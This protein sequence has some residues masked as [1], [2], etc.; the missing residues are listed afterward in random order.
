M[1]FAD[2]AVFKAVAEEGGVTAA[3]RRLHRVQSSVTMRIQHLEQSLGT[4]LFIR[5]RRR[6]VLSPAGELFRGYVDQLL[7]LGERARAAAA[8]DAPQGALRLG[9]LESTAASRLPP[10]LSAYHRAHKAVRVELVTGTTDALVEALLERRVDAAFVAEAPRDPRLEARAAFAEALVLIT[11]RDHPAVHAPRDV[12]LDTI[13]AFPAGC[14]YRRR[15]ARWLGPAHAAARVLELASYHAIVACVAS[16]TGVAL[17][18]RSVLATVRSG[19][20]VR[21]HPL[22]R[23]IARVVTALLRRRNERAP[24]IDAL[25]SLLTPTRHSSREPA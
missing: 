21:A 24:A 11:P 22:P 25:Q 7:E 13:I 15:L 1:D 3:A 8:G 12:A 18:P 4:A 5:E 20:N 10:L 17:V 16:G 19:R 23:S 6:M 14:A 9:T 2:L